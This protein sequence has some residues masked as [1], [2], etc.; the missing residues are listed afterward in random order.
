MLKIARTVLIDSEKTEIY[1]EITKSAKEGKIMDRKEI[2]AKIIRGVTVALPIVLVSILAVLIVVAMDM[3]EENS[4]PVFNDNVDTTPSTTIPSGNVLGEGDG[5]QGE[6]SQQ[7]PSN[8][9]TDKGLLFTSNG[10]GTCALEGLG[11]C[12]DDFIVVPSVSPNGDTVVEISDNAFKSCTQIKGIEL[13]STITRIGA[14]AFYCSSI[15]EISIPAS[16]RIIGNCAFSGC[17]SLEAI[18][19]E[20]ENT[21]Y[22]SSSGVLYSKDGSTLITYPAGKTDNF[23]IISRNVTEISDMAFYRC[24]YVTKVTYHGSSTAWKKVYIGSGNDV[25]EEATI[26]CAGDGSK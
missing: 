11:A 26:Y 3:S 6:G 15:K 9:A 10:D 25:I 5:A 24:N 20:V 13:P 14:Y 22:C 8:D 19:V 2:K 23:A 16:V 17:R 7:G 1:N 12:G 4:V 18:E 21:S